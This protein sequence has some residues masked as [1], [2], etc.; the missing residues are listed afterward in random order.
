[1]KTFPEIN[2]GSV[3]P[4]KDI[5]SQSDEKI[6]EKLIEISKPINPIFEEIKAKLIDYMPTRQREEY[7]NL[8]TEI[9][10]DLIVIPKSLRGN[11]REDESEYELERWLDTFTEFWIL[12][13]NK[14]SNTYK[15]IEEKWRII[16]NIQK[17]LRGL[18]WSSFGINDDLIEVYDFYKTN[19]ESDHLNPTDK[20]IERWESYKEAFFYSREAVNRA[21]NIFFQFEDKREEILNNPQISSNEPDF[22]E[23]VQ[24]KIDKD[25]LG[26]VPDHFAKAFETGNPKDLES[27]SNLNQWN[28]YVKEIK[29]EDESLDESLGDMDY[30]FVY[31]IRNQELYKIGKTQNLLRRMKQLEPDE[32]L[33]VVRSQNFDELER[34]IHKEFKEVR[35]PQSEYFRLSPS[36]IKKVHQLM[37]SQAKF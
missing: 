9:Q 7:Q 11:I 27:I 6:I 30:G 37:T 35:L 3:K 14:Y 34:S 8:L 21:A 2:I 32:I 12:S 17:D 4:T 25:Y 13:K 29:G 36:Q 22:K 10:K 28:D 5:Y 18:F 16:F 15:D 19:I 23:W 20:D 1:M 33:N 24:N 31:F 26:V